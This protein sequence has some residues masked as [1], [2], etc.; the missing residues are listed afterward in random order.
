[1]DRDVAK[2]NDMLKNDL[3]AKLDKANLSP[4]RQELSTTDSQFKLNSLIMNT[5]ELGGTSGR[6][7][8]VSQNTMALQLHESLINNALN[9]LK[10]AGK[11]MSEQEL[12]AEFERGLSQFTGGKIEFK[13]QGGSEADSGPNTYVFDAHDP[14]RIRFSDG[15]VI[16]VLRAGFRQE[17]KEDIP[18]QQVTVPLQFAM[19][20]DQIVAT[21]GT[22]KVSPVV[23]PKN[24]Q[25]QIARAGVIRKKLER[26]LPKRQF[27]STFTLERKNDPNLE[28]GLIGINSLDG[29]LTLNVK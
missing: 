3:I 23:R 15:Q 7:A 26:A 6:P 9:H 11:T 28:I 12:K 5:G 14:V 25:I 19:E 22:I 2:A 27:A 18:P 29:W 13:D 20:K 17:G 10:L 1:V 21:R 24:L 4:S 16:L 8:T